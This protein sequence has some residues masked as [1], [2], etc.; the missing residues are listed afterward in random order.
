MSHFSSVA[1]ATML[2]L[3]ATTVFAGGYDRSGQSVGILFEEGRYA[4]LSFGAVGPTV[5]G[6]F[7]GG[8]LSTDN[9][10]EVFF[11]SGAAF[12]ADIGEKLSYAIIADQPFGAK[13]SY[14][15]GPLI[16]TE[17]TL[18]SGALTALLRYKFNS[19]FSV[20]GGV[21][22][23]MFFAEGVAVPAVGGYEA[24]ADPSFGVGYVVGTAFEKPEIAL[25]VALTYN[26]EINHSLDTD[27]SLS[28]VNT[29][30]EIHTPQSVNLEFQTGVAANTLVFGSVRWVNWDGVDI[31]PPVYTGLAGPLVAYSNDTITYSLGVGRKFNERWSAALQFAFE[32]G[33]GEPAPNLGPTDG[34]FSVGLGATYKLNE[35]IDIT[36]G[37]RY[38]MIGDATSS[39]GGDFSGNSAIAGGLKIGFHF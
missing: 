17:A 8:A 33:D 27:E 3:L 22:G 9:A 25:R 4:E 20:Y 2:S 36:G 39:A 32:A 23:Q 10:G 15:A 7:G 12:K 5:S 6:T 30:T 13:I 37:V 21:R 26:S 29:T 31:A 28:P 35:T 38:V 18:T 11:Q 19:N 14:P 24:S 34:F 16:G 1:S